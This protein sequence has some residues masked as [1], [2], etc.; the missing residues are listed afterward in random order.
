MCIAFPFEI[1][2]INSENKTAVASSMGVTQTIAVDLCANIKVGDY[3]LV[4]SGYAIEIFDR[5][6]AMKSIELF[7][8]LKEELN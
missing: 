1:I 6:E 8:D 4:H 5:E 7:N 2:S 3:V